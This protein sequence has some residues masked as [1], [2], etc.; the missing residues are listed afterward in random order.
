MGKLAKNV[1][2]EEPGAG[3]RTTSALEL[4]LLTPE[5]AFYSDCHSRQLIRL[6]LCCGRAEER[7]VVAYFDYHNL[8]WPAIAERMNMTEAQVREVYKS[9]ERRVELAEDRASR[10][11]IIEGVALAKGTRGRR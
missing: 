10:V 4:A 7:A 11:A 2:P 6:G 3:G 5:S 8:P 9:V 1:E